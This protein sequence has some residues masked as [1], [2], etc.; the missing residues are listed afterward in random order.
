MAENLGELEQ[1]VLLALIRL[2]NE[3][4]GIP[5]QQELAR[6]AKR[7]ATFA[8]VYATLQRLEAKGFVRSRLGEPT[9]ERGGRRKK[10]FE[11]TPLGTRAL[12]RSIQATERMTQGIDPTWEAR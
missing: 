4:Y 6:V 12:R 2:G 11:P 8:T 10:Y 7:R 1:L 5:V 3:A 9:A